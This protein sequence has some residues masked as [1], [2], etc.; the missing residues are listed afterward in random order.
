M[1]FIVFFM[2]I[3]Y[4]FDMIFSVTICFKSH[5]KFVQQTTSMF[6]FNPYFILFFHNWISPFKITYYEQIF[7]LTRLLNHILIQTMWFWV[8]FHLLS[9]HCFQLSYMSSGFKAD[10]IIW[11]FTRFFNILFLNSCGTWACLPRIAHSYFWSF[12]NFVDSWLPILLSTNCW[13]SLWKIILESTF[14]NLRIL[15]RTPWHV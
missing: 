10:P 3:I 9:H 1:Y 8:L 4:C 6:K 13:I 5:N 11:R 7:M 2:I 15:W 12:I 14:S